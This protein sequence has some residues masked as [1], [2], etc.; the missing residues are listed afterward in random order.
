MNT[1]IF[2]LQCEPQ[3]SVSRSSAANYILTRQGISV[4]ARRRHHHFSSLSVLMSLSRSAAVRGSI[5]WLSPRIGKILRGIPINYRAS[6]QF[7]FCQF[8]PYRGSDPVFAISL[9]KTVLHASSAKMVIVCVRRSVGCVS[10]TIIGITPGFDRAS[11]YILSH[12]NSSIQASG[13][14]NYK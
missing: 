3:S 1:G 6:S 7:H 11:G 2:R 4:V 8:T 9:L 5:V 14:L 13:D 12:R 10:S